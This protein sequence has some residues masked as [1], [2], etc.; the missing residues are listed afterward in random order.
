VVQNPFKMGKLGV[1]TLL[2]HLA[3]KP[4]EKRIDTGCVV[5][6]AENMESADVKPLLPSDPKK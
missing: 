1:K 6:T 2:D 3:G 4:V 5:A